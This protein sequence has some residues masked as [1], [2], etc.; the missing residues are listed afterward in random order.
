LHKN[1]I[2][3]V[4]IEKDECQPIFLPLM[5]QIFQPQTNIKLQN[6]S[7]VKL[8]QKGKRFEIACYKNKIGEYRNLQEKDLSNV[9]QIEEV[10]VNVSKGQVASGKDLEVFDKLSKQEIIKRILEKGEIQLNQQERQLLQ[11]NLMKDILHLVVS[12]T[13][14]STTKKPYTLGIIE[15]IVKEIGFQLNVQKNAKQQ[16]L[17]L[18]QKLI[19]SQLIPIERVPLRVRVLL[20]DPIDLQEYIT[21]E[22]DSGNQVTGIMDPSKLKQLQEFIK[23]MGKVEILGE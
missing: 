13:L 23:E 20:T 10:F 7:V 4:L 8:K 1:E 16:S 19:D 22:Q 11:D 12:K 15:K 9:L 5:P 21:V 17:E 14:N 2:T 3:F 6:V 18:M